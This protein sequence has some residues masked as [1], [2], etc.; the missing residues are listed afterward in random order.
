MVSEKHFP[1]LL[2][3]AKKAGLNDSLKASTSQ[4]AFE[5]NISQQSVSRKLSFLAQKKLIER[6]VFADGNII[7]LT[8]KGKK[9]L[10]KRKQELDKIFSSKKKKT[11]KG[12]VLSGLGEGKY[13]V[14][15]SGYQKQFKEKLGKKI[16]PGTLNL[17][18]NESELNAFLSSKQKIAV[19]GFSDSRRSFGPAL[20]FKAKLNS[21]EGA[22]IVPERTNHPSNVIEFISPFFLRNKL[23]LK[24]NSV[25]QLS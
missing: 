16:F 9:L 19:E 14:N 6:K 23:N 22:V 4:L 10:F 2:L 13:Y 21:V 24:D 8:E 5:L 15:V 12:K 7:H 18:V 20:L 3:I 17:K 11:I 1:L 25:V